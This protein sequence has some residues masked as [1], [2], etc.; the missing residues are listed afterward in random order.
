[1]TPSIAAIADFPAPR[2]S[3]HWLA[4]A[5]Y[6]ALGRQS[7][8]TGAAWVLLLFAFACLAPFLANSMPY[9]VKIDDRWS[10]P[11]L[12]HLSYIDVTL[13]V[14]FL[15]F[16]SLWAWR[17]GRFLTKFSL[18][19]AVILLTLALSLWF[20]HPPRT[21]VH[22]QYRVMQAQ[23]RLQSVVWAPLRFSPTD[24]MRDQVDLVPPNP[25]SAAHWL[26][27]DRDGQDITSRMIHASRL[28]LSVG[29]IAVSISAVIGI[30][31]GGLMGYFAGA[32]DMFG[33]RLVEIFS[34]IPGLYLMLTVVAFFGRDIYLIMVIIGLTS[35]TGYAYFTR[36]EFLRLRKQDFV[37]A[38]I[39]TG[40]PMRSILFRHMLPNGMAPLLV[41]A[42]FGVAGA[43]LAESSLSFL[44]LG[45]V[46]QASWGD[47]L[48]QAVSPGGG[49]YWWLATFP[50]LAIFFSVFAFNLVGEALRDAIDPHTQK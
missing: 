40:T 45:V 25:P 31:L 33:L 23:G 16:M 4:E 17:G 34:S 13:L 42:T 11:L 27:T 21:V 18:F 15:A 7:A 39:A 28:S 49:F 8:R 43:I 22:E 29:F 5:L 38:A 9:A 1:M 12:Q 44:G 20:C 36:A 46:D 35:W 14:C 47:L 30:T 10:S 6:R 24:R 26:G 50:G 37:Q 41:S 48:N 32:M 19:C 3:R 2:A